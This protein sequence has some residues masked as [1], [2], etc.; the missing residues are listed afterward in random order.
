MFMHGL[1]IPPEFLCLAFHVSITTLGPWVL[2]LRSCASCPLLHLPRVPACCIR[3]I[4]F[5]HIAKLSQ[6]WVNFS[7]PVSKLTTKVFFSKSRA[8][9][10][11]GVGD[12]AEM[13][14]FSTEP[15]CQCTQSLKFCRW[16]HSFPVSMGF[17]TKKLYIYITHNES[18][19][20]FIS[21]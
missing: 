2:L 4:Q 11:D 13:K 6:E 5:R 18:Q 7:A 17:C 12:K 21:V 16:H 9:L 20:Q 8:M 14:L 3:P 15:H 10:A 1:L 19:I